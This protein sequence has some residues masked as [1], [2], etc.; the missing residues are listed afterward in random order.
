MR[1]RTLGLVVALAALTSSCTAW[2]WGQAPLAS[3][4]TAPVAGSNGWIDATSGWSH[5]CRIDTSRALWCG[6]NNEWGQVGNGTAVDTDELERIGTSTWRAVDAGLLSTCGVQL[7]GTLWCWG[8]NRSDAW[9]LPDPRLDV[10]EPTQVGTDADWQSVDSYRTHRCALKTDGTL[11]CWGDGLA[12]RIGNDSEAF[13]D[14]P[15]KIGTATWQSIGTASRSNCGVQTDGT[16]WCWGT[17]EGGSTGLDS[18]PGD[19]PVTTPQQVGTANDWDVVSSAAT[20]HCAIRTDDTLWCWGSYSIR[21]RLISTTPAQLGT[22]A[23]WRTISVGALNACGIQHDNSM[24]CWGDNQF[25]WVGDGT[26]DDRWDPVRIE[27]NKTW[28]DV[29]VFYGTQGLAL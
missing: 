1:L 23:T 17:D 2:T 22:A 24:W 18:Q 3:T 27:P 19:G 5:S 21:D 8:Y 26:T 4:S 29:D 11:W 9:L 25:G 6:G 12:F 10:W 13:V 15:T 16:L 7:D 20:M 14:A 28:L